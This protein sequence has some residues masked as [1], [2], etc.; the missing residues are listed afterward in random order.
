[1]NQQRLVELLQSVQI[2]DTDR[3]KATTAELRKDYYP[4]PQ[5]LLWL[6][7]ILTSHEDPKTRQ[8]ASVEA[9]RLIEAHWAA[10]PADQKPAIREKL[11]EFTLAEQQSLVRHA[12]ARVIA[13][14]AKIDLED[15]EWASLPGLL[16]QAST[17]NVVSQ[18]EVG[19]YILFSLLEVAGEAFEDKIPSLFSLFATTLE[20]AESAE[21]RANTLLC[22]SKVAMLISPEEDPE[23]LARFVQLFPGMVK[24]LKAAIDEDNEERVMQAF[25]VFQTLLGCETALLNTHFKDLMTFMIDIASNT[26]ISDDT[27]NQALSFLMQAAR[28]RKMKI[29]GTKD[30]GETL[31]LKAMQIA[32]EIDDDDDE[33]DEVN[34]HR[35]ALG[36]LD[37][38]ASSLPPRQVIVPL[39]AALPSYVNNESPQYRQA[40]ILSLGMCVEGAPDFIGT[41][42]DSLVPVVLKLLN[43]PVVGVRNA[44][45]NGV[46][47]LADDLSEDLGR[48]HA[49]L[50]PA[51]LKNL[52]SASVQAPSESEQR[53]NLEI[54]KAAGGAL[55]SVTE[56][57]EKDVM[58]TYLPELIPRLGRLL[59]HSDLTVKASAAGAMGSIAG[60]AE[61]AF[62]PYFEETMKALSAFVTIKD[63]QDELDLRATACDAMGSMAAAV[64]GAAFQ[65]YVDPLMRASE[66]ALHLGHPRLRETSYILWSTLAKVYEEGFTPFLEG[67]VKG[68]MESLEQEETDLDVEL[69]EHAK[70]LVGQEVT[71]GGQKVKV[72]AANDDI[73]DLDGMENDDDE[74]DPD[75]FG[76]SAI[77]FEKEIAIEVLGDVL[78]HTRK[79][80]VPYFEKTI[81]SVMGLVEH[82][83]E[84]VR[85][86]AIATLWRAYACLWALMEDHTGVKWTPGLPPNTQPSGEVLKLGEVVTAATLSLWEDEV[87]RSVVTDINR[88]VAATLK[89]CGPAIL[90]QPDFADRTMTILASIITKSHPCQQDIGDD[91]DREALDD[92]ESSEYDWLVIDTALDVIIGLSSALGTQ[93]SEAWK[94]FQ[95][96]V[97][98]FASSQTNFERSTAIGVIAECTATMGP[99][100]SQFTEPLLKL[101]LHRLTDEDIETKSNAAY[102]IG[103][104]VFHSTESNLYLPAFKEILT[105]LEP[106]LQTQVARTLDNAS[107]CVCRMIMAHQDQ[108]PVAEILPIIV[109]L[110]PLKEDYEENK[111]IYECITGLYDHQDPTVMNLTPKL[112]PVF[113]AVLDEPSEQLEDETRSRIATV[114][115]F[116]HGKDASLLQGNPVLMKCI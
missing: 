42:L 101:L 61:D 78:S 116:I 105:K 84:G 58:T 94:I 15:G 47:R 36:L 28:F 63:S 96:P 77:A 88:N 30:L 46:A 35:S 70:D 34:P 73:E 79:N 44:A 31:T 57:L 72:V 68:L 56:G 23:N 48:H 109:D 14:I 8:Q 93:F 50:I 66:E 21:V 99:G 76:V 17:S 112:L 67:V 113:A 7:H 49:E 106:L 3:L 110:L 6:L 75:G 64:G 86:T 19:V 53:K 24:V 62:L 85:K 91:D 33:D 100:V 107:G 80:F 10:Q 40:G 95:K 38:L 108:V 20:D 65:P 83:Y 26:E 60:S 9:L 25:E 12:S 5:T 92:E 43:D 27:R 29:Q 111:P 90:A 98:K 102:A 37:L 39:L 52:D 87:D 1:M 51:L 71:I 82:H 11:L 103:L 81:E 55:D 104:L 89:L 114:V 54:L 59:S 4:H 69:G 22:L 16:A 115:K 45:L 41:Q 32:T 74:F 2:P 18:R 13:A 97:M